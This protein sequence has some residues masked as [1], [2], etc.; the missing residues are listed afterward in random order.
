M[1]ANRTVIS[2]MPCSFCTLQAANTTGGGVVDI[3]I[4]FCFFKFMQRTHE[5]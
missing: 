5:E 3:D 2:N 1:F 4:L